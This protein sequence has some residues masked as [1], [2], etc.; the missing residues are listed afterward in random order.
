V[1]VVVPPE[2]LPRRGVWGLG[3]HRP[4]GLGLSFF[5]WSVSS[6]S[7]GGAFFSSGNLLSASAPPRARRL[8]YHLFGSGRGTST[9]NLQIEWFWSLSGDVEGGPF[10]RVFLRGLESF[11]FRQSSSF[12]SVVQLGRTLDSSPSSCACSRPVAI[13]QRSTAS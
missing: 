2:R 7:S 12:A 13:R 6:S 4:Q 3:A 10:Q 5:F 11:S 1:V 8:H 9:L